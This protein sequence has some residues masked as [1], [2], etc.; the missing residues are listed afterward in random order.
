MAMQWSSGESKNSSH[1]KAV[2]WASC[3]GF[4]AV[5]RV[6]INRQ[7][8]LGTYRATFVVCVAESQVLETPSSIAPQHAAH[9]NFCCF[10]S[11]KQLVT[12]ACC[13]LHAFCVLL[14]IGYPATVLLIVQCR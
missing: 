8:K 6:N 11:I 9:N 3:K 10:T 7:P 4:C 12:D 5:V 2:C 1:F 13:G 14:W